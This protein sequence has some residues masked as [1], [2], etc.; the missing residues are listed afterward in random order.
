M[1]PYLLLMFKGEVG[2]KEDDRYCGLVISTEGWKL[3]G[4]EILFLVPVFLDLKKGNPFR[5]EF[6]AIRYDL[7]RA[8]YMKINKTN[9]PVIREGSRG[10]GRSGNRIG[11]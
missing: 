6:L 1:K 5:G 8:W 9:T 7:E 3:Y 2:F 4:S 10:R 11:I